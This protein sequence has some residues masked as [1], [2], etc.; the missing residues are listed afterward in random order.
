LK[1]EVLYKILV[2][3]HIDLKA[4]IQ[5]IFICSVNA[6]VETHSWNLEANL[7]WF[8]GD[9]LK[10]AY[11]TLVSFLHEVWNGDCPL[12]QDYWGRNTKLRIKILLTKT[13]SVLLVIDDL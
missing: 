12:N 7:S 5:L 10:Q 6:R 4:K 13:C 11:L 1:H 3:D 2:L 8:E 9:E